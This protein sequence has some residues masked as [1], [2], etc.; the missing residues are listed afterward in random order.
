M[1]ESVQH[2]LQNGVTSHWSYQP[3]NANRLP[4]SQGCLEI[5][6]LVSVMVTTSQL[7]FP[8]LLTEVVSPTSNLLLSRGH[9]NKL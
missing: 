2:R 7:S 9:Q 3:V 4:N 5:A 6:L 1:A 8:N